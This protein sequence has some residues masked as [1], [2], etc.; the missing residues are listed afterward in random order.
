M[1]RVENVARPEASVT[2]GTAPD[3]TPE[4]PCAVSVT[5]TPLTGLPPLSVTRATTG[6]MIAPA[7]VFAGCTVKT[8]FAPTPPV[9]VKPKLADGVTPLTDAVT[10]YEPTVEFATAVTLALPLMSVVTVDAERLADAPVAGAA[11]VT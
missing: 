8:R 2:A 10:V 5:V 11:N 7:G 6:A 9:L 3:R 1:L 4:P